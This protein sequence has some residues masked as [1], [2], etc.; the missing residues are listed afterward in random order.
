MTPQLRA[1]AAAIESLLK[2]GCRVLVWLW[3][4]Q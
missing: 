3:E 2:D 1:L 4:S